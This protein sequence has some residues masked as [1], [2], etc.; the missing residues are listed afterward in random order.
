M[1]LPEFL[2]SLLRRYG[3]QALGSQLALT[4]GTPFHFTACAANLSSG[5]GGHTLNA[6]SNWA[7][8]LTGRSDRDIRNITIAFALRVRAG[9]GIILTVGSA[10]YLAM[11]STKM[12]LVTAI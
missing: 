8:P 9:A 3:R 5:P 1:V 11:L 7:A 4:T 6:L 2:G 10:A 12:L